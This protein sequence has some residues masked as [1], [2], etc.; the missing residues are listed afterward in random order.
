M[1]NPW[2]DLFN[3]WVDTYLKPQEEEEMKPYE[4]KLTTTATFTVQVD[5]YNEDDAIE[6]AY[7]MI[8]R[9]EVEFGEWE[10]DDVSVEYPDND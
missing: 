4:V 3:A 2:Q 9:K 6:E 10:V 8:D 1:I 7:A 5:A